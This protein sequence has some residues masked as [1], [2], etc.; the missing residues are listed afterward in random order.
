MVGHSARELVKSCLFQ[1]AVNVGTGLLASSLLFRVLLFPGVA[2]ASMDEHM[3]VT[4][5][6]HKEGV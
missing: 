2:L 6:A 3:P 4:S 5:K 1:P